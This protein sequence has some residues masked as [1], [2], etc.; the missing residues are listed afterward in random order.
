MSAGTRVHCR[1][2][3]RHVSWVVWPSERTVRLSVLMLQPSPCPTVT[4]QLA[5]VAVCLCFLNAPL[6]KTV[7]DR[8]EQI[9]CV[10]VC[11]CLCCFLFFFFWAVVLG[12][13]GILDPNRS[14]LCCGRKSRVELHPI[15]P[16]LEWGG[17]V[18]SAHAHTH[19]HTHT[20]TYACGATISSFDPYN[21][22][23]QICCYISF[24]QSVTS[25][26]HNTKQSALTFCNFIS[27]HYFRK[28]VSELLAWMALVAW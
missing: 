6:S 24:R 18:Y 15:Q 12:L 27:V 13:L 20:H 3:Q 1:V 22:C 17:R 8:P 28:R 25:V 4:Q 5:T 14:S 11:V 23:S 16:S 10:C 26:Q 7:G 2:K 9:V 21:S 19:T